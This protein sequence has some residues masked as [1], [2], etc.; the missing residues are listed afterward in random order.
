MTPA[1]TE[2]VGIPVFAP[3]SQKV[4]PAQ[5]GVALVALVGIARASMPCSTKNAS[6][7][8]LPASCSAIERS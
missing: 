6:I 8:A 5:V 3:M 2:I 4:V 7:A 1:G